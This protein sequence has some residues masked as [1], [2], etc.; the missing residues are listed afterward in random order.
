[1][2]LQSPLSVLTSSVSTRDVICGSSNAEIAQAANASFSLD[3][4]Q[5]TR[6]V[7][8]PLDTG[9]NKSKQRFQLKKRKI[10]LDTETFNTEVTNFKAD[11][12]SGIFDDLAK[13]QEHDK[14]PSANICAAS[15]INLKAEGNL[16]R[17]KA[18]IMPRTMTHCGRSF[19]NLS[20][21]T[22]V[23]ARNGDS[24]TPSE[25]S[26]RGIVTPIPQFSSE[27]PDSTEAAKIIDQVLVSDIV[28]PQLPAT[29]SQSSCSSNNLT[30]T[31]MPAA[32]V[33]ENPILIEGES[34]EKDSYGWFV[35]MESDECKGAD[36]SVYPDAFKKSD[37]S[38]SAATAPKKDS[39]H[40]VEAE[41]AKA[42]DT[43]D[44]VIGDLGFFM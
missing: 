37:L 19:A 6:P 36:G 9:N 26:S 16:S 18:R 32:Q 11:F 8:N 13:A 10:S 34:D 15:S 20:A 44:D 25:T 2:S 35:E 27:F 31:S 4:G 28:F 22:S 38:F 17:K 7:P 39:Q 5:T 3:V 29:I 30:P 43:V 41:W 24:S 12:L 14:S 23:E 21:I 42:A 1:M 33:V 40:D